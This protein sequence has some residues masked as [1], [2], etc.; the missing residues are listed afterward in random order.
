[1]Q[2]SKIKHCLQV[3][4]R[5]L[6]NL[7]WAYNAIYYRCLLNHLYG[8]NVIIL[9]P[10]ESKREIKRVGRKKRELFCV[11]VCTHILRFD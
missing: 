7:K 2:L 5:K 6:L 11:C 3:F 1:M 10:R 8:K 4:I 9:T